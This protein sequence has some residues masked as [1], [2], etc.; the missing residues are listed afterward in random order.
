MSQPVPPASVLVAHRVADFD[1][2]KRVFDDS[3]SFRQ[4]D[5][6]LGHD[7]SRGADDPS[8]VYVYCLAGDADKL[9]AHVKNA[10]LSQIMQK[11]GVVGQPEVWVMKPM[12][13]DIVPDRT[14]AG[15]VAVH[16]VEDYATWREVYDAFDAHRKQHGIVGHAVNQELGNPKRVIVYHQAKEMATL[17]AFADSEEL[18][19]R[20]PRAGVVGK[21]AFHF[22]QSVETQQY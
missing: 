3:R 14:L 1:G 21:P 22:F 4:N 19:E 6:I 18:R 16:D 17:R 2:W 11:A 13:V 8:M 15:M 5:G 7:V 12:S 20:M 10:E 9:A